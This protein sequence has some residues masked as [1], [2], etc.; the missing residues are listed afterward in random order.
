MFQPGT[1]LTF[2]NAKAVLDAGVRAIAEGQTVIDFAGVTTVDSAAVA[3]LLGWQRAAV[4]RGVALTFTNLPENLRSLIFL[5][6]IEGLLASNAAVTDSAS[7]PARADL[8]H[9]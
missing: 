8:L 6:D 7:A 3:S 2:N 1:S 5:Y 4:A 9:H